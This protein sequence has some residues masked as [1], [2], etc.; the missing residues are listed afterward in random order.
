VSARTAKEKSRTDEERN[1]RYTVGTS[2]RKGDSG[3]W[4]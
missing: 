2:G 1:K 3:E 4:H